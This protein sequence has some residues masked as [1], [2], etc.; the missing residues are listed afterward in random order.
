M[1]TLEG[2]RL[3]STAA[4]LDIAA[5]SFDKPQVRVEVGQSN[6]ILYDRL[7]WGSEQ[8]REQRRAIDLGYPPSKDA[9]TSLA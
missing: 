5:K 4:G 7:N 6:G 3:A 8:Q 1:F 2:I 9:K